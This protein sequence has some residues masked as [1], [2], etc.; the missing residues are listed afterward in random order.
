MAK[1][2]GKLKAKK[3]KWFKV[4]SPSFLGEKPV[5]ELLAED[6]SKLVGKKVT[7]N[8]MQ[9]TKDFH[10]QDSNIMLL[11]TNTS[12]QLLKTSF[13]RFLTSLSSIKRNARRKRDRIDVRNVIRTKDNIKAVIKV[14]LITQKNTAKS[15][16]T[17]IRKV[18]S[19][20]LNE[21]FKSKTLSDIAHD[22]IRNKLQKEMVPLVKKVYPVKSIIIREFGYADRK[23]AVVD[24]KV[25]SK[26]EKQ[27][28]IEE[29]TKPEIKEDMKEQK[30][31]PTV[32]AKSKKENKK[33]SGKTESEKKKT[34]KKAKTG[35]EK[36]DS[37]EEKQKK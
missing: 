22:I 29:D 5:A 2:A 12:G 35:K 7:F 24:N 27:K 10:H 4:L 36:E 13:V 16:Q 32:E 20:H 17:Q 6:I 26:A 3:K 30:A 11:I 1:Q 23:E 31:E 37:K 14:V 9:V 18:V 25:E 21:V 8:L 19:E 15:V 34:E 33:Q 28:K